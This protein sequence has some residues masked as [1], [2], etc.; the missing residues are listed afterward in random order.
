MPKKGILFQINASEHQLNGVPFCIF[1]VFLE[2]GLVD[3]LTSLRS[4]NVHIM[5]VVQLI[6]QLYVIYG[7]DERKV[8]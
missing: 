1:G 8:G 2:Y 5:G 7:K 3:A 6:V 4:K